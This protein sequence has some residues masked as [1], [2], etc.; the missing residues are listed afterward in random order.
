MSARTGRPARS[1][2]RN[3]R[4]LARNQTGAARIENLVTMV[5]GTATRTPG[6]Q[7]V[8]PLKAEDETGSFIRFRFSPE[9]SYAIVINGGVARFFKAGGYVTADPESEAPYEVA[10]PYSGDDAIRA[11]P[12]G[13]VLYL[14]GGGIR[15]KTL[16]RNDNADWTLD[17]YAPLNGPLQTQNLDTA[18]TIL[19]SA[20]SGA[21][22]LTLSAAGIVTADDIGTVMRLDEPDLDLVPLWTSGET[23]LADGNQRR[24]NGNV[25][26][27]KAGSGT[28][29]GPNP[30]THLDGS[31]KAGQGHVAWTFLHRG[32]GFVRIDAITDA[33]HIAAT[34]LSRLPNSVTTNA[35]YR[36]SAAAWSDARGWP[37][38]VVIHQNRLIFFRGNEYWAS[39]ADDLTSHE[40][41]VDPADAFSGRLIAPDG[42]LVTVEWALTSGA[43]VVGSRDGE[44]LFRASNSA[45]PLTPLDT[46]PIPDGSEGSAP[47]VP[48]LVDG[49]AVFI[50]RSRRR[51]H[52][53]A[54]DR[55]AERLAPEEITLGCRHLFKGR[56]KRIAYQRDPYR[57][58]WVACENGDLRAITFDPKNNVVAGHRHLVGGA[59]EDLVAVPSMDGSADEIY[60]IV[61]RT[62]AGAT[63]RYIERLTPFFES[64]DED[65]PTA[66]G[67]WF[68][69]C[70][71]EL[72]T[73]LPADTI[74]GLDHL[75]GEEVAVH[76]AGAEHPR[77]TVA[78]GSITLDR[79]TTRALVG[80][81][82]P[83][84]LT[85]LPFEI[86]TDRGSSKGKA[87]RS[88]AVTVD[89]VEAAGGEVRVN[90]GPAEPLT[91]T[92][93]AGYGAAVALFTGPVVKDAIEAA[94]AD[95]LIVEVA[96]DATL[97]FSLAGITPVVTVAGT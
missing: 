12:S 13:N 39:R 37:D 78:N 2:L 57:L 8:L 5:E 50:G 71:A 79:E 7:F 66:A 82:K 20:V 87:K 19:A 45:D 44:W 24:Y 6:T 94:T 72:S 53:I 28:T 26:A 96:G 17:D 90:G 21:V 95:E 3:R 63:R 91:E 70:G 83:W 81:P 73:D 68:V 64:A 30:P 29:A 27:V 62:I 49:G 43:L 36:W 4:D 23:G 31:V 1:W 69:D 15:P 35:T 14:A 41:G 84:R 60:F 88:N 11:A 59:V 22:T 75:E 52:Y 51:L 9:D 58:L 40:A 80:L 25:Y 92:G 76:I 54:F 38:T 48:A 16:R 89:V 93:G 67:A 97:P 74:V 10:V 85:T 18:K 65:A 46:R 56:A 77:R 34:V 47:H 61:R 33:T 42:S 55:L 32:Y 86:E